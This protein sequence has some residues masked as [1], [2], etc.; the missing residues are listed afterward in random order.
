PFPKRI[1]PCKLTVLDHVLIAAPRVIDQNIQFALLAGN[2]VEYSLNFFINLM[3]AAYRYAAG[4]QISAFDSATSHINF[5]SRLG[6]SASDSIPHAS[7]PTCHE[8]N[9][10]I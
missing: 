4:A 7:T 1:D 3:I 6:E 8:C 2:A 5:R 9:C 10:A